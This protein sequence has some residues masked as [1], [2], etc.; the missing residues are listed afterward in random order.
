MAR[1]FS[2]VV[3][4]FVS[5]ENL[6]FEGRRG[7]EALCQIAR[8]IGYKDTQY[9][10]QLTHKA[11]IGDLMYM[12]E[13]NPGMI[14]AM[15]TWLGEQDMPEWQESIEESVGLEDEEECEE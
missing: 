13:D 15:V 6:S 10:G 8:A 14:E 7:V 4:A 3:D 11:A 12:L 9:Y 1:D 5:Q 2:E